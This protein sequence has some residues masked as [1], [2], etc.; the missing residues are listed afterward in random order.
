MLKKLRILIFMLVAIIGV[1]NAQIDTDRMSIIGRNALYFEDYILAIQYFN[2]IIRAKPYLNEPYYF[3]AI[4][5][6]N[7]DDLKGAES[8]CDKALE[9]NPYFIDAYNLRGVIRQQL[10][11]NNDAIEDYTK[12]LKIDPDNVNLIINIGIAQIRN[13]DYDEAI[14]TYSKAI[15]L[16]PN[17]VSSW[18]NRGH[19]KLAALDTLGALDDFSKSIELNPYI[20]DGYANRAIVNYQLGEFNKSLADLE[21]AVKLRP[22]EARLFMI[23]GIIRYQLDDL[24]GTVEDFDKV[25]DLEPKNVLAYQNRGILRAQIGDI[26]RAID[27]FS[28]VLALNTE[29]LLTLYNR[30]LLYIEIGEYEKALAD[31]NIVADN[32][33]DFAPVYFNRS[34]TKEALGDIRGA[35]LDYGTA[36]KLEMERREA[37]DR[38]EALERSGDKLAEAERDEENHS[39]ER[40]AT[41][42]ESDKNIRNHDKIAV[43][44]DFGSEPPEELKAGTLRGRIQNRNIVIDLESI[45]GLTHYPGDT[46]VHRMRYFN[47]D[48]DALNRRHIVDL[49]LL[50]TNTEQE[51]ERERSAVIFEQINQLSAKIKTADKESLEAILL[52]RGALYQS[53][54]NMNNALDDYNRIIQLNPNNYLARFNRAFTR[55]KMVEM[56]RTLQAENSVSLQPLNIQDA[57]RSN[58]TNKDEEDKRIL[59]FDLIIQD[60]TTITNQMPRF[61]LAYFNLGVVHANLRNF[62]EAINNLSKAIEINPDLAEAWF[63]RGLIR[64]YMEQEIDGTLDLSKAGELGIFEAYNIIK[65]Y[66]I[67]PGAVIDSEKDN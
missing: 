23:R 35:S 21:E 25:I 67:G 40:K 17:M 55:F 22:D 24:R 3:R 7:L 42:K 58:T 30:A 51:P 5:K 9:L 29:D 54:Q 4:G 36:V 10:G 28:R 62:E 20:P 47:I 6:Y 44:D 56:V 53:V 34:H 52:T 12:A 59:D 43:L 33:P 1:A 26:N 63:N 61:A 19:A 27:D 14:E 48:V 65:R 31:L 38:A 39:H 13:E 16:S 8:D 60:L 64:I 57:T 66:G 49:P 11:R 46:L 18:L 15:R 45:F 41:R 50:F 2:Q 32:H 37:S